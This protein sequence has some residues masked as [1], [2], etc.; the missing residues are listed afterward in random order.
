MP[1]RKVGDGMTFR[2]M[3]QF[4]CPCGARAH[5][6]E[7]VETKTYCVIHAKPYCSDFLSLEPVEFLRW[8]R[9]HG[10]LPFN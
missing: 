4:R 3:V 10:A 8:A 1:D 2:E 7:I 9:T 6:G 5:A